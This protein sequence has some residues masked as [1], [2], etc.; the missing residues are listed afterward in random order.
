MPSR[1][2]SNRADLKDYMTDKLEPNEKDVT[3]LTKAIS[4]W[5]VR[6]D[7]K[8]YD[9]N[10]TGNKLSR[11]DIERMCI[12]RLNQRQPQI[13]SELVV[14]AALRRAIETRHNDPE[15]TI[16]VWN[17]EHV[18][19]PGTMSKFVWND[20]AVSIN[21][22][23]SPGYRSARVNEADYGIFGQLFDA[24]FV[25]PPEKEMFLNWLAYGLQNEVDKPA[26]APF[27]YS[28]TKGTGK[29]TVCSICTELF[30]RTN[31]VTSNGLDH[32]LSK[33]NQS[34]LMNK[35]VVLEEL[36]LT[37]ASAQANRLKMYITETEVLTER[38]GVDAEL[39]RQACCF[40]FT[41]NHLPTWIEHDDRRFYV[42][43]CDHSGHASGAQA[44]EFSSL[45]GR[46]KEQMR[47]PINIA[48][49][50]NALMARELPTDF[51]AQ[52]LNIDEQATPLMRQIQ[53]AS[54]QTNVVLLEQELNEKAVNALPEGAVASFV[55]KVLSGNSNQTRHLM[56][57]LQWVRASVKWGGADYARMIWVRP[58]YLVERGKLVGPEGQVTDLV[59][60]L[61]LLELEVF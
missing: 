43:D 57:E 40:V 53:G 50:Y 45:V 36:S 39:I 12:L 11:P 46:I 23:T 34:T 18:S 5:F 60:H 8:F 15:Q 26:W 47:D 25:N 3:E 56:T 13:T 58:G 61:K 28:R 59:E 9:V 33:F 16:P 42:I 27:L 32:L 29:S 1:D 31:S 21:S 10:R 49:L 54:A 51:D 55:Q 41:S 48:K 4:S 19:A 20:G 24:V 30:G 44:K 22:W 2:V 17:G 14:K 7:G 52:T 37:T 6:K 35:L 38:K